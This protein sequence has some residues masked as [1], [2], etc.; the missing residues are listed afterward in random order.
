[1]G[2]PR[3]GWPLRVTDAQLPPAL[4]RWITE[5]GHDATHVADC[6]LAA[7]TLRP[8]RR[9]R[10]GPRRVRVHVRLQH[11][12]RRGRRA[13]LPMAL[14]RVRSSVRP[15]PPRARRHPVSLQRPPYAMA[16]PP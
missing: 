16:V 7:T 11:V 10:G 2:G 3:S 12:A 13:L 8:V 1:M 14:F 4:A 5:H 15:D 9:H 6:G